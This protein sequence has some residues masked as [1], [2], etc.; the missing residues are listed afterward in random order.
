MQVSFSPRGSPGPSPVKC[1]RRSPTYQANECVQM[2]RAGSPGVRKGSAY[3]TSDLTCLFRQDA[4][5]QEWVAS[6]VGG[7]GGGP[8]LNDVPSSQRIRKTAQPSLVVELGTLTEQGM[9][10]DKPWET[11]ECR[12]ASLVE[13]GKPDASRGR[14]ATGPTRSAGFTEP[15]ARFKCPTQLGFSLESL[16]SLPVTSCQLPVVRESDAFEDDEVAGRAGGCA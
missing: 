12:R 14:K 15:R 11:I 16:S 5:A 8:V 9:C 7:P 2:T 10:T 6:V 4:N 13:K 1:S 3:E